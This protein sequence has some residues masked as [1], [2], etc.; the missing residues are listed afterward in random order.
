[1]R[2]VGRGWDGRRRSSGR[3]GDLR[4]EVEKGDGEECSPNLETTYG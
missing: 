2:E 1:M 3:D 4:S